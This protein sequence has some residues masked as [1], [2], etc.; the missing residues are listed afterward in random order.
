MNTLTTFI[1]SNE[2]LSC[3][4][5]SGNE[6]EVIRYANK[7]KTYIRELS[8]NGSQSA[9]LLD[10]VRESYHFT[11]LKIWALLISISCGIIAIKKYN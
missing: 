3:G 4:N 8:D 2:Q 9:I 7:L 1:D 10:D 5:D 6:D 11:Y